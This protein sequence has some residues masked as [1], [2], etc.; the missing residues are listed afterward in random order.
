MR[1][2][3]GIIIFVV[4]FEHNLLIIYVHAYENLNF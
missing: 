2:Y 1:D 3:Y 4:Y